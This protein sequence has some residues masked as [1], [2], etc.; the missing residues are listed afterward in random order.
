MPWTFTGAPVGLAIGDFDNDGKADAV[1]A[2][3]SS[4]TGGSVYLVPSILQSGTV[5]E[6]APVVFDDVAIQGLQAADFNGDG[7]LD[8]AIADSQGW[9]FALNAGGRT[10]VEARRV[11]L[12]GPQ[13]QT[14]LLPAAGGGPPTLVGTG[15]QITLLSS[16]CR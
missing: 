8:L 5:N 12:P 15:A 7:L 4:A 1:I 3:T 11:A 10:F 6:G 13:F 14:A 16:G 2:T 9:I